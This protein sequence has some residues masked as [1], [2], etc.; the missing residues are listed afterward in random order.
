[1]GKQAK[2]SEGGIMKRATDDFSNW[3]LQQENMSKLFPYVFPQMPPRFQRCCV[4]MKTVFL[5]QWGCFAVSCVCAMVLFIPVVVLDRILGENIE[6]SALIESKPFLAFFIVAFVISL[7]I[8]LV[9]TP[10]KF[11]PKLFWRCPC[12]GHPFPYYVLT[13]GG[14]D[15]KEKECFF[16]I[17]GQHIKYAKLKFC[18]L[19]IPSVCPECKCKFFEMTGDEQ[20]SMWP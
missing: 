17:K 5:I 3:R 15:L 12:C 18:P 14:N 7:P 1:M 4:F 2:N 13:R 19:I 16:T 11:T 20:P 9:A 6:M 10:L 8:F